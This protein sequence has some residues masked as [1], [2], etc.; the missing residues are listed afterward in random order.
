MKRLFLLLIFPIQLSAQSQG[1]VNIYVGFDTASSRISLFK[2]AFDNVP[3]IKCYSC[4]T[5]DSFLTAFE[6]FGH[7]WKIFQCVGESDKRWAIC[8]NEKTEKIFWIA[9]DS[10]THF[11]SWSDYW[12]NQGGVSSG[13]P[14]RKGPSDKSPQLKIDSVYDYYFAVEAVQG[15]WLFVCY[16]RHRGSE[17]GLENERSGT[18]GWVRWR[19]GNEIFAS[20]TVAE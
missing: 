5:I 14:I 8:D 18:I 3:E 1:L 4:C 15:D 17:N 7:G 2:S 16:D 20:V 9:K 11:Q 12:I 13:S 6:D 10:T 19:K